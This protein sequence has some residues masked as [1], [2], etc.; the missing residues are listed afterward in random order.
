MPP[1]LHPLRL[2]LQLA[3]G[4]LDRAVLDFAH[5]VDGAEGLGQRV[6]VVCEQMGSVLGLR[7]RHNPRCRIWRKLD[8]LMTIILR[9]FDLLQADH[10]LARA[11]ARV[12]FVHHDAGEPSEQA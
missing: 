7:T 8:D 5:H 6:D 4:L 1:G 9:R 11:Q 10:G 3:G 2:D 12:G